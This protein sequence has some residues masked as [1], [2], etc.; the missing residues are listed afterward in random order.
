M[1]AAQ[2]MIRKTRSIGNQRRRGLSVPMEFERVIAA[3]ATDKTY[4]RWNLLA[5]RSTG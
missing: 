2:V 3:K 4:A 5:S 1:T